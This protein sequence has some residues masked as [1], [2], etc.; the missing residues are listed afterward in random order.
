MLTQRAINYIRLNEQLK[1]CIADKSRVTARTVN[2][3]LS[4]NH[5]MLTTWQSLQIIRKFTGLTYEEI[6]DQKILEQS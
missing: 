6:L 2:R 3:W 4:T 5:V 1:G